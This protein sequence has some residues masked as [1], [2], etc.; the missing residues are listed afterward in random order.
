MEESG[1]FS[2]NTPC[3][4][5]KGRL[6]VNPGLAIQA[7]EVQCGKPKSYQLVYQVRHW[8]SDTIR[9]ERERDWKIWTRD[10]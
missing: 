9:L 10:R 7:Y 3:G 5:N 4:L 6:T 2:C 8:D 1:A